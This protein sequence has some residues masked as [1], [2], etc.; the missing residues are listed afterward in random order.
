[1]HNNRKYTVSKNAPI[2][3]SCS[4]DNHGPVLII[5]GKQHQDTFKNNM[6]IQLS[7]YLHFYLLYLLLNSCDENEAK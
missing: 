1:M 6:H 5:F 4:F 7:L 2:L 3:A